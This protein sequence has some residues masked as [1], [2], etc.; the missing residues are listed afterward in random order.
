MD[1]DAG[2]ENCGVVSPRTELIIL[3]VVIPLAVAFVAYCGRYIL[4][5]G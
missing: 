1:Q 2:L 3:A 5:W 4:G